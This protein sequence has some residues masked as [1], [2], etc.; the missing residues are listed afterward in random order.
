MNV[1]RTV[2]VTFEQ[3]YRFVARQ[4]LG[5]AAHDLPEVADA[6]EHARLPLGLGLTEDREPAETGG[7]VG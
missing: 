1:E 6:G 5:E 2:I 4:V 3:P 7:V